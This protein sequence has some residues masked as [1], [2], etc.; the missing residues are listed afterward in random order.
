M[1]WVEEELRR[2]GLFDADSDYSGHLAKTVLAVARLVYS[3]GMSGAEV[4]Q[5]VALFDKLFD[6]KPLT[7][8]TG[9]P[10]EWKDVT[11]SYGLPDGDLTKHYQNLRCSSVFK[12]VDADGTET[13]FDVND[14][15]YH[16]DNKDGT[17]LDSCDDLP[18]V[19]FPYTP[20]SHLTAGSSH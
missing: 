15:F 14:R 13:V 4:K 16:T 2:A 20:G 8:L 11:A 5:A 19:T 17:C 6:N 12:R 10:D 3:S 7:A 1:G 9:R 18:A